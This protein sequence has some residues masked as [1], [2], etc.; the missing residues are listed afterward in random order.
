MRKWECAD[1]DWRHIFDKRETGG[2]RGIR[3]LEGLLTPTPLAGVRLRPLGHL[4]DRAVAPRTR[5]AII[6]KGLHE[7]KARPARRVRRP[8]RPRRAR[9]PQRRQRLGSQLEVD[10]EFSRLMR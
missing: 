5:G 6:R 8:R 9:P 7:G 4:S 2:E 10:S 1:R 3:T